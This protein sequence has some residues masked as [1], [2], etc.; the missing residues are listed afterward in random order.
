MLRNITN[1]NTDALTA[2]NVLAYNNIDQLTQGSS[3]LAAITD[4]SESGGDTTIDMNGREEAVKMIGVSDTNCSNSKLSQTNTNAGNYMMYLSLQ[5]L[6]DGFKLV[7]YPDSN[8]LK[9]FV[10]GILASTVAV[11]EVSV[12]YGSFL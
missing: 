3:L 6:S 10:E 12:F 8:T 4:N 9:T 1:A 5:K 7:P 2:A 11:A